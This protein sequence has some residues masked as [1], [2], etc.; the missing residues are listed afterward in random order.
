M[1]FLRDTKK[2]L[3]DYCPSREISALLGDAVAFVAISALGDKI[4]LCCIDHF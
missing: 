1:V 3:Y 2:R 4:E